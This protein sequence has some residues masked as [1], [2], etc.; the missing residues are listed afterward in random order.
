MDLRQYLRVLQAHWLLIAVSVFV[1]T[2]VAAVLAWTRPPTYAARMQLYVSSTIPNGGGSS[3]EGYA[4]FLLSQQR[5][6]SYTQLIA[7]PPVVR[8]VNK[9]LGLSLSLQDFR[10]KIGADRP[11]G[12]VLIDVTVK[13][14]SP[15]LA[16]AIADA[17][18]KQFPSFVQALEKTKGERISP[19]KVSVT[20][21]AQLP[22]APVSPRKAL[23]LVL[24]MLLGLVVGVGA[25][26][27]REALARRIRNAEDAAAITGL[28]V[29]GSIAEQRRAQR[30]P[31]VMM[32]NPGSARAEDYRRVRTNLHALIG[33]D[34]ARA[35]V[36]SSATVSEGKTLTTANLGI[37][38]AQAGHR[39]VVVDADLRRSK[40]AEVMGIKPVLGLADLLANDLPVERA[41]ETWRE[42]LPLDV[43]AA[44][45][46]PRYPSE[47]LGSQRFVDVLD[48]LTK[49]ADIVI[50]DTPAL[51]PTT[52]AAIVARATAGAV[53]VARAGSTRVRELL[54]A[55][56]SLYSVD[57]RVLGIILNRLPP[58]SAARR[59]GVAYVPEPEPS[60]KSGVAVDL[61]LHVSAERRS[62]YHL[63][64]DAS[65]PGSVA[66]PLDEH[67]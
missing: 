10:S 53:L 45:P 61:P 15:R 20:S 30:Q 26:V 57:A 41:L 19:V 7:S 9:Q 51:L 40:L 22:T 62:Q 3:T 44:A 24:G 8:A 50:L 59:Y 25:A 4:A 67:S 18:G 47:L 2:D 27:I 48:E 17:L 56:E 33:G 21:P 52:D 54:S 13:D 42:G 1:C 63:S 12:T 55:I 65:R 36:V 6:V 64:A 49:R 60:G 58:R 35:F 39:V 46:Q 38:F 43:L 31:L 37:A 28:P 5:A 66:T 34:Q 32:E 14:R 16:K 29:L 11:E 23:Y